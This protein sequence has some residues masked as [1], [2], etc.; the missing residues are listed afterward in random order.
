MLY[1][2]SQLLT[3]ML[4]AQNT[5]MNHWSYDEGAMSHLTLQ[6]YLPSDYPNPC[7]QGWI[8]D[9]GGSISSPILFLPSHLSLPSWGPSIFFLFFLELQEEEFAYKLASVVTIRRQHDRVQLL[10]PEV[11]QMKEKKTSLN[12]RYQQ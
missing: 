8:N 4:S 3:N 12:I 7:P 5:Q 1:D 6:A 11:K 10:T 2:V 9:Q